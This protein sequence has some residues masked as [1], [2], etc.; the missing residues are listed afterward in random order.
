MLDKRDVPSNNFL[1]I[2]EAN[3]DNKELSD[4]EFREFIRTSLPVVKYKE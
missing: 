2:V 4:A 1:K 3:V